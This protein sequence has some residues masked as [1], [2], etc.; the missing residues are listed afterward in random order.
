MKRILSL[1]MAGVLTASSAISVNALEASKF[2]YYPDNVETATYYF[3]APDEYF[4][5]NDSVGFY[6]YGSEVGS[7]NWPGYAADPAPEIGEHVYSAT[8]P[9]DATYIIFNA[10]VDAGS[11]ADPEIAKVAHQTVDIETGEGD[12]ANM[13]YVL[14]NDAEHKKINDFSGAVTTSG[15]W[16]A[17]DNYKESDNYKSYDFKDVEKP[18]D[19]KKDTPDTPD[20]V[21]KEYHRDDV[22]TVSYLV[23]NTDNIGAV[24]A[25]IY[26]NK[27]YLKY[28]DCKTADIEKSTILV[29]EEEGLEGTINIGANFEPK[30]ATHDFAGD[31]APVVTLTF[32]AAKDFNV[33]DLGIDHKTIKLIQVKDDG[34]STNQLVSSESD[35]DSDFVEVST[36]VTCVH[37][38]NNVYHKDD[39]VELTYLLGNVDRIGSLNATLK[40]NRKYLDFMSAKTPDIKKSTILYN[41]QDGTLDIGAVFDPNGKTSY[42]AGDKTSLITI[43]FKALKDFK[44]ADLNISFKTT[45]IVQITEDGQDKKVLIASEKDSSVDYAASEYKVICVH[46]PDYKPEDEPIKVETPTDPTPV[47]PKPQPEPEPEPDPG[48]TDPEPVDPKPQPEPKN[49]K[50]GDVT[51]DNTVDSEDAL[52]VLRYSVELEKFDADQKTAADVNKD[53]TID[54]EDSLKILRKSVGYEDKGTYFN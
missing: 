42:F 12:Y 28:S 2:S 29:N 49:I 22:V 18:I 43:K 15:D 40:Y 51:G 36:E 20:V 35:L 3:L 37:V 47:D 53:N 39:I 45:R 50:I 5:S 14:M 31:K 25:E 32:V 4:L 26:Y 11:P 44:Y 27:D 54:S 6:Y 52:K 38:D 16:L 17:L 30:G 34:Q 19:D 23:G 24:G 7:P 13:I 10:F 46:D 41:D 48:K 9:A 21:E 1:M 33:E 8:I